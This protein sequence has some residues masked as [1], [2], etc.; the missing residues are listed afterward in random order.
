MIIYRDIVALA[1]QLTTAE[2]AQLIAHLSTSLRQALEIESHRHMSWHE[3]IDRTA[4]S[5][6]DAPI[7]RWEQGDDEE[8]EPLE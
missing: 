3:F 8:R 1:D 6:A 2:K 5:L 4:G 7:Q